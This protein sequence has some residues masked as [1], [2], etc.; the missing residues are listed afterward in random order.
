M[1]VKSK[2]SKTPLR[3]AKTRATSPRGA[4]RGRNGSGIEWCDASW[5]V[6]AG[7]SRVSKGC[8]HCYAET[9]MGTRMAGAAR[10]RRD[11]GRANGS[12]LDV[13]LDVINNKGRWNNRVE[14]L[15]MNLDQPLKRTTP[16]R[17]FVNS[18]SDL[19]HEQVPFEYIDRVF[20]VMALCPQHRFMV[21]TKR[22]ERMRAYL[23]TMQDLGDF[24]E[25]LEWCSSLRPKAMMSDF[26]D[27]MI[28]GNR[29]DLSN[30]WLGTS[31]EDQ[32]TAE[33]RLPELL[34]CPAAG[35]FVSAEPLLG[36][37]DMTAFVPHYKCDGGGMDA[38]YHG[39]RM[40]TKDCGWEGLKH[41]DDRRRGKSVTPQGHPTGRCVCMKAGVDYIFGGVDWVI[42]GGESGKGARPCNIEW[43]RSIKDQCQRAVVP[44]FVKQLG[45]AVT[46]ANDSFDQWPDDG[47]GLLIDAEGPGWSH[48]GEQVCV[49]LND[50]K[51]G[52][53]SEWP[54]D[55]RVREW[56]GGL[57][58]AAGEKERPGSASRDTGGTP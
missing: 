51:G 58:G 6:T 52:D 42:V 3:P 31:V 13:T 32:A 17:Y 10:K 43:I 54:A 50:R 57:A 18:R 19:F 23:T 2:D 8:E 5:E 25:L 37:V 28:N 48:Q 46:I 1:Q 20:A 15:G 36:A 11:E 4:G 33:A 29:W 38:I 53:P 7:C 14:L 21:L 55:L 40:I 44:V 56:P 30:V 27:D 26:V 41:P 24:S 16:T 35:R 39:E 45:A 49:S 9:L 47:D 22:P 34:A 12:G